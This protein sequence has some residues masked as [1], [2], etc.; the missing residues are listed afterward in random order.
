MFSGI[1]VKILSIILLIAV[2]VVLNF[3]YWNFIQ[4]WGNK[5]KIFKQIN[6][7]KSFVTIYSNNCIS[8]FCIFF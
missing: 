6:A 4:R 8:R 7:I 1:F 3:W 5:Q 2:G